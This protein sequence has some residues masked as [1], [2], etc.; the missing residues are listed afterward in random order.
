MNCLTIEKL[1]KEKCSG[2]GA[3]VQLC[4]TQCISM[5]ENGE[6]FYYPRVNSQKCV[7]CGKCLKQCPQYNIIPGNKESTCYAVIHNDSKVL[8]TSTSGGAF[9]LFAKEV[10]EKGGAVYGCSMEKEDNTFV[11]R[12]IRVDNMSDLEKIKGSKYVQSIIGDTFLKAKEDLE[13]NRMVLF[14]GTPCQ[15]AGLKAFMQK[16]YPN[17]ITCEVICH[18][19]PSQKLFQKSIEYLEE[20]KKFE[21]LSFKF[22]SK[23]NK[24]AMFWEYNYVN[25]KKS[26]GNNVKIAD[27]NPYYMSFLNGECYRESCYL[28]NYA[29]KNRVADITMGDYWGVEELY[30]DF[31]DPNGVSIVL[32]NNSKSEEFFLSVK[33]EAKTKTVQLGSAISYNKNLVRPTCRPEKRDFAY[34]NILKSPVEIFEKYPYRLPLKQQVKARLKSLI[35]VEYKWTIK[36]VVKKFVKNWVK[37]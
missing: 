22:R 36:R 35:P 2:C 9:S 6:G 32:I 26:N 15:I 30:P 4:P 16:D 13:Q 14:S 10:I 8:K 19:V 3:C 11:V 25:Q 34:K 12:H 28:C 7:S 24:W 5:E 21:I 31:A 37:K 33:S 29:K 20:K 23:A 17:L 27:E 1:E 18:G